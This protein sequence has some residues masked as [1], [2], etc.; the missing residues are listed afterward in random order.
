M[1]DSHILIYEQID[2]YFFNA[3]STLYFSDI[4]F[5]VKKAQPNTENIDCFQIDWFVIC[6]HF[7]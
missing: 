7:A 5:D 6:V 1:N 4:I 2:F 3:R